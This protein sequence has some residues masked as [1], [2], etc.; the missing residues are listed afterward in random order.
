MKNCVLLVTMGGPR[1]PEEIPG[2]IRNLT[3]RELPP[4]ALNAVIERYR[5]IGGF[6]PLNRITG[7]QARRLND[8][9]GDEY[10]CVPAFRYSRPSLEEALGSAAAQGA[11][12]VFFLILSPFYASVTTGNYLSAAKD[13]LEKITGCL[14][15]GFIHS[16]YREPLF[17]ESWAEKVNQESFD[18]RAFYL[19]SAHSLPLR[20]ADEPYRGQIEETF[21][22]IVSRTRIKHHGLAWQSIPSNAAEPWMTP[23]V[24]E[25]LDEIA[26]AGFASVVQVPVGFT[27]DHIETLYD[28]DI[29]HRR[30]A[31]EK[32]L[33]FRRLSS[34]NA[35]DAFIRALK[36]IVIK[37]VRDANPLEAM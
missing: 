5:A 35:G 32:G 24:E 15:A 23:T 2:F 16:W 21:G 18:E 33:C 20:Y 19:F 1:S 11:A 29:A 25:K 30:Y 6:S 27:A 22:M 10:L 28:I 14:P 8:M 12:R 37:F 17:I 13:C 36:E 34:L 31:E 9:L 3:G 4:R 26:A 7:D